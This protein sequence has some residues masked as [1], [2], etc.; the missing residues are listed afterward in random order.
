MGASVV[1]VPRKGDFGLDFEA[2]LAAVTGKTK[3]IFLC[4]PNNPTGDFAPIEEVERLAEERGRGR[5][6]EAYFEYCGRTAIDLSD[7]LENVIVCRTLSK[8]FSMAGRQDRLPRRQGRDRRRS[9]T[10]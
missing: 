8:A 5:I 4:N 7:R 9:S 10:P 3:V 2:I 6:D 1:G